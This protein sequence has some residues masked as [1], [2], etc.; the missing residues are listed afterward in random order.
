MPQRFAAKEIKVKIYVAMDI[1]CIEC[2][3]PSNCLGLFRD[4]TEAEMVLREAAER[5]SENWHG[6][7][8][9]ELFEEE[10]P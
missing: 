9:F 5:Q 4:K 8:E 7:H 10:L 6:Q 2:G 1:G 3:E